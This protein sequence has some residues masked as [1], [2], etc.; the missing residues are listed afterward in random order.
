MINNMEQVITAS[1][2]IKSIGM[3]GYLLECKQAEKEGY[4]ALGNPDVEGIEYSQVFVKY[5]NTEDYK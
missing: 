5:K 3:L 2:T 4:K 1:K